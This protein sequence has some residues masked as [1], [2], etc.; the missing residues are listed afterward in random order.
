MAADRAPGAAPPGDGDIAEAAR[1]AV[2]RAFGRV[3]G[4][5]PVTTATVLR[6]PQ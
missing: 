2:R 5:K 1:Q 4:F 3:L 6:L